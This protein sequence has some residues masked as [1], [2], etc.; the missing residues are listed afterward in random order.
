MNNVV[1]FNVHVINFRKITFAGMFEESQK[2]RHANFTLY[3]KKPVFVKSNEYYHLQFQA[4]IVLTAFICK[5]IF[6][7]TVQTIIITMLLFLPS[8]LQDIKTTY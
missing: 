4:D 6:S 1:K 5:H 2:P 8:I 7:V 3:N